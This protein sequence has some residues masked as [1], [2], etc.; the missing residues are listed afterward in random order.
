M[1]KVSVSILSGK[2]NLV[3]VVKKIDKTNV[4]Y[5][6]VDIMDGKFVSNKSFTFSEV[7]NLT[8]YTTKKLDVHLMVNDPDKYIEDYAN[9]NVEYITIHYEIGKNIN[10]FID[11]IKE[12]GIKCGISIKP[13]TE[14]NSIVPY[15]N[16]IDLILLMSVNPG[17]GGQE[18]ISTSIE[19][20]RALRQLLSNYPNILIEVDGGINDVVAPMCIEAGADIL[21]A[22]SFIISSNNYQNNIDKL[23]NN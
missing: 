4:D 10:K 2:D 8:K 6:H 5:I 21:V 12:Y 22:G 7:R 14:I 1:K 3:A 23:K 15:L 16:K 17:M 19:K 13:E 20:I 11:K 9:L 18:F